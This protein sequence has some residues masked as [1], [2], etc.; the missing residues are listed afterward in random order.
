MESG[1]RRS[2]LEVHAPA[3]SENAP[4][5]PCGWKMQSQESGKR[6]WAKVLCPQGQVSR[7]SCICM[8]TRGQHTHEWLYRCQR[9]ERHRHEGTTKRCA[10]T[11]RCV[12]VCCCGCAEM[13]QDS[14]RLGQPEHWP[15][16]RAERQDASQVHDRVPRVVVSVSPAIRPCST[17]HTFRLTPL[18][19]SR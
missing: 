3:Q 7:L 6:T 1:H 12:F 15:Q 8:H 5:V 10:W 14:C 18:P 11:Y 16:V 13:L 4:G 2:L 19:N 17:S 9:I